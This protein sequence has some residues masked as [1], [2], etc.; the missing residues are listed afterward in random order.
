VFDV[1]SS[2]W[3]LRS[4]QHRGPPA[5]CQRRAPRSAGLP[6]ARIFCYRNGA[7]G[8]RNAPGRPLCIPGS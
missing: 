8:G 6:S 5:I 2:Q 4:E 1:Q 3:F 7:A